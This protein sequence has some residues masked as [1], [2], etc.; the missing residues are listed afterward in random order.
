MQMTD[1]L[2]QQLQEELTKTKQKN[3]ELVTKHEIA[4]STINLLQKKCDVRGE[5]LM[6]QCKETKR[7][8]EE[9]AALKAQPAQEPALF[10]YEK[11]MQTEDEM[12]AIERLRFFL[13][14]SL[15]GQDWLDVEPFIDA[16]KAQPIAE[17]KAQPAQEPVARYYGSEMSRYCI[18]WTNGP[19]PEGTLLCSYP[20]PSAEVEKDAARYR[21]I[22][23][24]PQWI[25][26]DSDYR[27]DE[28][29]AA[30]DFGMSKVEK[31]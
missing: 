2:I 18:E 4:C 23:K 7:L 20:Q 28:V 15:S 13:S 5:A 16:L 17:L 31:P 27:E 9:L 29:D 26:F 30:V 10:R 12:D 21:W 1:N 14:L 25:G 11:Y 19:L 3:A 22:R 24:N 6:E 8:Q